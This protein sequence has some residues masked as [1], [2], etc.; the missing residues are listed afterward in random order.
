MHLTVLAES[1]CPNAPV[2]TDRLTKVLDGRA[3]ISV[4][5]QEISSEDEAI[6]WGMH[7]SP[8]LLIDG[9]G[10]HS[11]NRGSRRACPVAVPR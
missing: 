10:I 5:H 4:S 11:P 7:G 6:R 3:G 8:T 9:V 1:T 2:L